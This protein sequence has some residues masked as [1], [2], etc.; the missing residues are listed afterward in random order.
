MPE[1]IFKID[2]H[3]LTTPVLNKLDLN[4]VPRPI[5]PLDPEME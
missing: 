3:G 4:R 5:F 2:V 1:Q